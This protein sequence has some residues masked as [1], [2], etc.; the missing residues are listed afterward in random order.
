MTDCQRGCKD[1]S[2]DLTN[3]ELSPFESTVSVLSKVLTK[4]HTSDHAPS[5]L[6]LCDIVEWYV[7]QA[8]RHAGGFSE[9]RPLAGEIIG[10]LDRLDQTIFECQN[11]LKF[12]ETQGGAL[13]A[14]YQTFESHRFDSPTAVW[15]YMKGQVDIIKSVFAARHVSLKGP[16]SGGESANNGSPLSLDAHHAPEQTS[17]PS[18]WMR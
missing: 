2:Q 9:D 14:E 10:A 15:L 8:R 3:L 12:A 17:E 6:N 13:A 5:V 11:W 18:R 16:E 1:V 7:R 4:E